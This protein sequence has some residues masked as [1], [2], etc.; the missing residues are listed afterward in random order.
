[1]KESATAD[2][3]AGD[4]GHAFIAAA[5]AAGTDIPDV[6]AAGTTPKLQQLARGSIKPT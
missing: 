3:A 4:D 6:A 2:P 5:T 1:M